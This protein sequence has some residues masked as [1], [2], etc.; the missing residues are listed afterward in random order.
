M[1]IVEYERHVQKLEFHWLQSACFFE[2]LPLN[3]LLWLP[4]GRTEESVGA[5][6]WAI[7]D[8]CWQNLA[9]GLGGEAVADLLQARLHVPADARQRR[10]YRLDK[11]LSD[12]GR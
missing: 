1:C 10:L 4:D 6:A 9:L 5:H 8:F 11:S 7:A 3:I 12:L 2:N